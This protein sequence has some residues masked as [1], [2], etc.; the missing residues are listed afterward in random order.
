MRCASSDRRSSASNSEESTSTWHRTPEH[1]WGE[2]R[3]FSG[4]DEDGIAVVR[5][6]LILDLKTEADRMKDAILRNGEEAVRPWNLRK[7]RAKVQAPVG[8]GRKVLKID[9]KKR[10]HSPPARLH[11]APK[12]PQMRSS[13]DKTE[14][15]KFSLELS[16][17]EIEEDFITM[18][19]HRP[20]RRP[21]KRP[22]LVKKQL[23][24]L[25][26]GL[27]LTEVTADSYKVIEA[28]E[29]GKVRHYGKR[30]VDIG[31]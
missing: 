7:R 6:K 21:T 30:K 23:D 11:G 27:W 16:K 2:K 15:V 22:K 18:L 9:D 25:L 3:R 17:K 28:A 14:R 1:A 29:N 20:P 31:F 4:D 8:D 13:S 26:P 5:Q 19:G 24:T 10:N 12:L